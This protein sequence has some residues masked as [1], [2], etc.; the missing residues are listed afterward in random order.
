MIKLFTV[1]AVAIL[2]AGTA[3]AADLT[4]PQAPPSQASEMVLPQSPLPSEDAALAAP[5]ESASPASQRGG[6]H[7]CHHSGET[8]YLTN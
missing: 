2:I 7:G 3:A 1:P 6:G 8:V 4:G 5:G